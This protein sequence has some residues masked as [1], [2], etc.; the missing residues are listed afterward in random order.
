MAARQMVQ[1]EKR[2]HFGRENNST[3]LLTRAALQYTRMGLC[4]TLEA[5]E[6]RVHSDMEITICLVYLSPNVNVTKD[7]IFT[8][9]QQLL[10]PFLFLGDFSAMHQ[11]WDKIP[12]DQG[13]NLIE[14]FI[15]KVCG[16]IK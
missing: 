6:V 1:I 4:T 15:V 12:V 8:I 5:V 16:I 7:E 3:V 2:H 14:N 10:Y 9:I 13:G 11:L